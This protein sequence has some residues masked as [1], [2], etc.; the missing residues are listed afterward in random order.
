MRKKQTWVQTVAAITL[1]TSAILPIGNMVSA[2]EG[3]TTE[4][5]QLIVKYK[6]DKTLSKKQMKNI[7]VEG[8]DED[9]Q[10]GLYDVKEEAADTA[11]TQLEKMDN[12][13]YVEKNVTYK[14]AETMDV[15]DT[16]YKNQWNLSA[17]DA[18]GAWESVKDTSKLVKVAVLDT[19][20]QGTHEDLTGRVLEGKTFVDGYDS[21]WQGDDQGHGTFV[22]GI[23]AAKANNGKGITGIAGEANVQILPVKVMSKS[24][25][26]DAFNIAQGIDYAVDQG[27]DVINMSLSGEYSETIEKAVKNAA[28]KGIVVVAASG[29]GGGNADASYPAAL[30]NVLS[31]GAIA[32]KDQVYERSNYGST[33]DIVAPGVSVLST[34]LLGDLGTEAGHY[35]TG[36]GT[37]YAAPHVAAVAAL[38]K[39]N[40]PEATASQ[41]EEAITSTAT[42]LNEEG[43]DEKTGHGKLNA[44]AALAD[45]VEIPGLSF[46]LP[47]NNAS[48]VGNTTLQ[49]AINDTNTS[50]TIFYTDEVKETN[51][52]G[53]VEAVGQSSI[54]FKWDT[55]KVTDGSHQ[56]IA[57]AVDSK[58]NELSRAQTSVKVVN[59]PQSGYMFTVTTPSDT[60]AKGASVKLYE[61][62]KQEDD[63]NAYS[64]NELWTG[65]TDT[66]GVVRVPSHVG[67]DLKNL[68]VVVQGKF[69][70]SKGNTWFMYSR[71]VA[72]SGAI[73]LKSEN[74]VP[75]TLNTVDEEGKDLPGAQYFIAMKDAKETTLGSTTMINEKG[76]K[77]APTVYLDKGAYNIFSYHKGEGKTYF[78]S[79]TAAEVGHDTKTLNF[80]S[81]EAGEVAI[82]NRDKGLEN[83]VLYLYNDAISEA[84][85]SDEVITGQKFFVTPGDY[86]YMVDAE[87][88]DPDGGENWVYV[89]A[90]DKTKAVIKKNKKTVIKA[91]GSIDITKFE[92]DQESLKNYYKQRGLTYIER[93]YPNIAYKL[94]KAFYTKQTFGDDYGNKLAGMYRGSLHSEDALY[95]KDVNTG[96]TVTTVDDEAQIETINFGDIYSKYKVMRLSD[97][98]VML[99]SHA[100]NA[101]NPANRQYYFYSFWVTSSSDV[102]EGKYE[103]SLTLDENP[104]AKKGLYKAINIDMQDSGTTMQVKNA[105]GDNVPSYITINRLE[106]TEDGD[107]EWVQ[108]LGQNTDTTKSLSLPSNLGLSDEENGNVAIIRYVQPSGEYSYIYRQFTSLDEL[109]TISIPANMQKVAVTAMDGDKKLDSISTRLWMIKKPVT[110]GGQTTYVTANNLQNYKY[111]SVYLEPGDFVMEGNYVSL[112]DEN[113]Q[114]DNYYFLEPNVQVKDDQTNTVIFDKEKLA[115][116]KVSADATGYSDV[117]GAIVYPYN[118][119]SHSFIKTLRVGHTFYVPSNLAMDLQVQLG[120]GDNESKNTI[121][122]YFLSKGDQTFQNGQQV[123]WQ[124]GGDFKANITLAK[125]KLLQGDKLSGHTSIK[126]AYGNTVSSVL[127]NQSTDYSIADDELVAYEK[128]ANGQ[129]VEKAVK[130]DYTISHG[131]TTASASSIKPVLRIYDAADNKVFEEASLDY[132]GHIHDTNLSLKD[133][134]YRA[135]LALAASPKG[136]VL[137]AKNTGAFQIG[138]DTEMVT[139]IPEI[140]EEVKV[141][142]VSQITDRTTVVTGKTTP[143]ASVTLKIG[144]KTI[145]TAIA[146]KNG[147]YTMKIAKQKAGMKLSLSATLK[148]YTASKVKTILVLD[149]TAPTVKPITVTD[150]TNALTIVTEKNVTMTFTAKGMTYTKPSYK[151]GKYT[152]KIAKLPANTKWIVIVKD[153]AGNKTKQT[154]V[155]VDRTAPKPAIVEKVTTKSTA[156]KGKA[157]KKATVTIFK[158]KVKLASGKANAKGTF[159]I[160]VPKQKAETTLLVVVQ[161]AA[162]N[163]SKVSK[164]KV[165]K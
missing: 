62:V 40:H 151:N 118:K 120:F 51:L 30:P 140:K 10:L 139:P 3:S 23:I 35:S 138:K 14:T 88:K 164:V 72:S 150:K 106:K 125:T 55:T 31:V 58:G 48:V 8:I 22:S 18:Q 5:E 130:S 142:T 56:V 67:T 68:Q 74:T 110:I 57:V 45:D 161:D 78:L 61:K 128:Q 136:P 73:T 160:K 122:N 141:P 124:V 156:I 33:L 96:K 60:I 82:D 157:E 46:L 102:T 93:P 132:Y 104:L 29:N 79:N 105:Q 89:L 103:I 107:S 91:G 153:Q 34:S 85:G 41:V 111:D 92:P 21:A 2:E 12:V 127:V 19:G 69:D 121:W 94:D 71:E 54:Q 27:V 99:D 154:G 86:D 155:V 15:N 162:K 7:G 146:D 119:Y 76:A 134:R 38:Y 4:T 1:A 81:R 75:V 159:S 39:L 152:L 149:R 143:K 50:Q 53:K 77:E 112:P 6:T 59:S 133:G 163:K 65:T 66:E 25:V 135:E 28:D 83:G 26:G 113:N 80:D 70:T 147:K 64:Y 44:K 158:G 87:V 117:R 20:V 114:K 36:S 63:A 148:G 109:K 49:L 116:M 9:N 32:T 129:I 42:D 144:K 137:S 47:K 100:K 101:T 43:W 97:N 165:G 123:N 11:I 17:I 52:I 108:S 90:N 95:K 98:K 84:I 145:H 13:E 126:D 115:Q 24:G 131:G 37:S 16:Y